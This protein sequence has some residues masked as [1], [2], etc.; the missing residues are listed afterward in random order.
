VLRVLDHQ[1]HTIT[2]MDWDTMTGIC[3]E[4]GACE[5]FAGVVRPY[6][7][8]PRLKIACRNKIRQHQTSGPSGNGDNGPAFSRRY[9]A[10]GVR[11][12]DFT[13]K[14]ARE[15]LVGAEC[16]ICARPAQNNDH[17]HAT[18]Q[19]RGTLCRDCNLLLGYAFDDV[20]RLRAAADYLERYRALL[21][22]EVQDGGRGPEAA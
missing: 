4:C 7:E 10:P 8:E 9:F 2:D 21:A 14:Q 17:D 22:S 19:V 5:V 18:G 13:R 15:R 1:V 16:E 12:P 3:A 20:E 6:T 11:M